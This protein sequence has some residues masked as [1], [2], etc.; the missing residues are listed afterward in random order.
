MSI[1]YVV[2]HKDSGFECKIEIDDKNLAK[3]KRYYKDR[4]GSD[5]KVI[6]GEDIAYC[7]A[8]NMIRIDS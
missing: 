7:V 3:A 4:C 6:T 5:E 1:V 8:L 2:E